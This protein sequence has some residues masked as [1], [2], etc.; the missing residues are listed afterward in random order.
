MTDASGNGNT[1]TIYERD[2]VDVGQVR[3]CAAV[4]RHERAGDDPGFGLAASRFD[5][6]DAGGVGQSLDGQRGWRDVIYKANDTSTSR[7]PR[8]ARSGT[9]ADR[10]RQL[11]PDAF[12]T[13]RALAANTWSFLTETYDG[14]TLRLY[15][16]GTQVASP[17]HTGAIASSTNPLAD[18]R[19]QPVQ[20]VLRRDDRRRSRL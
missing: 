18:R 15:V 17:A 20:P 8:E 6:D 2:L 5:R 16:N 14:S 19:R 4:Q 3:G 1:V 7:R 9:R 11:M 12:G 13:R 10:R